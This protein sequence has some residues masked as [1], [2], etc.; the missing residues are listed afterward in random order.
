MRFNALSPESRVWIFQSDRKLTTD[1]TQNIRMEAN[2][3]AENWVSHN[4][5]LEAA[6]EIYHDQF[7][8]LAVDEGVQ[9]AS[10]CSIDS[11]Y[12]FI[13]RIENKYNLNL[14]KR[15]LIAFFIKDK[16]ELISIKD[17]GF[18]V[19]NG[20]INPNTRFFNAL[21]TKKSELDSKWLVPV[22]EGWVSRYL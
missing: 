10:G 9:E 18:H 2:H 4:K 16:I 6:A 15:D 22:S 14:L 1:E 11:S 21:I 17:I 3:F 8:V 20:M 19:E 7:L 5:D 13:E 12:N